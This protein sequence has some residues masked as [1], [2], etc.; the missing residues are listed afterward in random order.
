LEDIFTICERDGSINNI[1]P[2]YYKDFLNMSDKALENV[3]T[4]VINDRVDEINESIFSGKW[5]SEEDIF[6]Y[7]KNILEIIA[8]GIMGLNEK[9]GGLVFYKP[10]GNYP[11]DEETKEELN[12]KI[13]GSTP[14]IREAF[15][16][17][18]NKQMKNQKQESENADKTAEKPQP[19]K[20]GVSNEN[21]LL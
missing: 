1:G 5:K 16:K 21:I 2:D 18:I 6:K 17:I 12:K 19:P 7:I 10:V 15:F 9:T 13:N 8:V 3:I 14:I 11:P 20:K 4:C